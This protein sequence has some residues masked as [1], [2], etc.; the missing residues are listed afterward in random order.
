MFE[1]VFELIQVVCSNL[2]VKV[3]SYK[4]VVSC[5]T[6]SIVAVVYSCVGQAVIV[7]IVAV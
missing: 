5:I 6:N 1:T 3:I 2:K 4:E 7:I